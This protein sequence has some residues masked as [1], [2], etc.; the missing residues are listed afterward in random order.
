[1]KREKKRPP[2]K[3]KDDKKEMKGFLM[4]IMIILAI[5]ISFELL[6]KPIFAK[7][8]IWI[9]DKSPCDECSSCE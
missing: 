7:T 6:I 3:T 1:M 4:F 2:S 9:S 8:G 5:S